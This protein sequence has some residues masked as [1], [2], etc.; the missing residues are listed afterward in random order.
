[1]SCSSSPFSHQNVLVPTSDVHFL[2]LSG[3]R[4]GIAS[5]HSHIMQP[6]LLRGL[7]LNPAPL[8]FQIKFT[9]QYHWLPQDPQP[10]IYK[11]EETAWHEVW[12][13]TLQFWIE[14]VPQME[15]KILVLSFSVLM[16]FFRRRASWMVR[17]KSK[18]SDTH[19]YN[20]LDKGRH[21]IHWFQDMKALQECFIPST[22]TAP[23]DCTLIERR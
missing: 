7:D 12:N 1:M 9:Q 8:I 14:K 5:C 22:G 15:S 6:R 11:E 10:S 16:G 4:A 13:F 21:I 18:S 17:T 2:N 3:I 23:W 20:S 19:W